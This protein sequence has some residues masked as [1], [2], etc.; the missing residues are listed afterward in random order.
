MYLEVP[1]DI[2]RETISVEPFVG[3]T[4]FRSIKRHGVRS[5]ESRLTKCIFIE[6]KQTYCKG[7]VLDDWRELFQIKSSSYLLLLLKDYFNRYV[8]KSVSVSQPQLGTDGM[9]VHESHKLSDSSSH[10][11]LDVYEV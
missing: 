2:L 11:S 3:L 9:H 7:K 5:V 1:C 6:K 4:V 8:A 10:Y